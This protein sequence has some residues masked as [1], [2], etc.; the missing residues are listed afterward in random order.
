MSLPRKLR[1]RRKMARMNRIGNIERYI[2]EELAS[3][4]NRTPFEH[5]SPYFKGKRDGEVEILLAV[6]KILEGEE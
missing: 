6:Q 4:K 3:M 2:E 1:S 5:L